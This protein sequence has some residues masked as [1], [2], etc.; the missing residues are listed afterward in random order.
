M[1]EEIISV[2]RSL[3][4]AEFVTLVSHEFDVFNKWSQLKPNIQ[5]CSIQK[6]EIYGDKEQLKLELTTGA[7]FN[8]DVSLINETGFSISAHRC[9]LTARTDF[10]NGLFTD[11]FHEMDL[12]SETY[13]LHNISDKSQGWERRL[14]GIFYVL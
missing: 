11:H 2:G 6:L 10:F 9:V 14:L 3:K 7:N 8:P 13:L 12:I 5:T 4:M 1:T